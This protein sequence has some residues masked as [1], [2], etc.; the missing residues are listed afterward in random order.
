MSWPFLEPVSLDD[1]PD[2]LEIVKEP[3]GKEMKEK[4]EKRDRED[5]EKKGKK[6]D[7]MRSV[8]KEKKRGKEEMEMQ[9]KQ[10][11]S[12]LNCR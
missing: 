10:E 12:W 3:M 5:M 6:W 2:Y 4:E 8:G 7:R 9:F 1:A 11:R